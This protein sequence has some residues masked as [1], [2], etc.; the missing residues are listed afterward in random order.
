MCVDLR[1][2]ASAL[3]QNGEIDYQVIAERIE[4]PFAELLFCAISFCRAE[5]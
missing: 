1:R 5:K 4:E 2:L 3:S